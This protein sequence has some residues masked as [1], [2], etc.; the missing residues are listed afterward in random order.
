MRF[1]VSLMVIRAMMGLAEGAYVP[2]SIVS[3]V[4]ASKPSRVGLNIGLQQMAQPFVGLGLGPV[5]AVGLCLG[6][7]RQLAPQ[8]G[9][10]GLFQR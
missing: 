1:L 7:P 4:E 6:I 3:T 5:I 10:Q 2:A 8:G 9:E